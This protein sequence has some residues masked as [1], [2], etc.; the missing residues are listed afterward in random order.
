M[1]EDTQV[2]S[3]MVAIPGEYATSK[4][5]LRGSEKAVIKALKVALQESGGRPVSVHDIVAAAQT[6]GIKES[7]PDTPMRIYPTHPASRTE[8]GHDVFDFDDRVARA[9]IRLEKKGKV[10]F[11][12]GGVT[13]AKIRVEL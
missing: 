12:G 2:G 1:K 5:Y 9:L 13:P 11:T 7:A 6:G 3:S 10:K 8:G 4:A